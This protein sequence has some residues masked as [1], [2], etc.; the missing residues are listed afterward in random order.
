[1]VDTGCAHAP[2]HYDTSFDIDTTQSIDLTQ[3]PVA[4]DTTSRN[5]NTTSKTPSEPVEYSSRE[6]SPP[7][8]LIKQLVRANNIFLLHHG[9]SL[10]GIYHKLGRAKF[11]NALDRYWSRF[12]S[13]WDVLLH[14]S[15]AVDIFHGMKL[16]AGGE[17]GMGVGE[18]EWGSGERDVLEDF[19][20]RTEGLVDLMVSRFGEPSPLQNQSKDSK[21]ASVT[22][23]EP[24]IG[25]GRSVTAGDGVVFSGVGALTRR[26]LRDL[27]SWVEDIYMYGDYAYGVKDSP[28]ADRRKRRRRNQNSEGS[29][30]KPQQ[31]SAPGLSGQSPVP[32]GIPP[33]IVTAAEI[34]LAK[35]SKAIDKK[36]AKEDGPDKVEPPRASLDD[37]DSWMKYLTLGYG[38]TWGGKRTPSAEKPPEKASPERQDAAPDPPM[39]FVEPEPDVDRF[40]EKLREQ[41][42]QE[43][44]GYFLIG[45]KGTLDEAHNDND[46][47]NGN[48]N[49]RIP[50]RA[51]HVEVSDEVPVTPDY[52]VP[53]TFI[54]QDL[55]AK[56]K[57]KTSRLR[58]IVYV[59]S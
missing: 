25:I 23:L 58:A 36:D 21:D 7:A 5:D 43:N 18:E 1:M 59:V 29:V 55:S 54:Q 37:T 26:S 16:A 28:A 15:P 33:P 38:T 2:I 45:L 48:W 14:G 31:T 34:S 57:P 24:W 30:Q 39:R 35:A 56:P 41:I 4:A 13:R 32:P 6:V 47:F 44:A 42:Q 46:D 19:A 9:H 50:L 27:S 52:E 17:L 11:C 40:E 22:E 53:P 10:E 8:L 20:R 3:L 12:A 49:N 51:V